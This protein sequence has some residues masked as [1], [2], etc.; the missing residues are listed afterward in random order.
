MNRDLVL[1]VLRTFASDGELQAPQALLDLIDLLARTH[2]TM[3]NDDWEVIATVGG[4][5]WRA[6]MGGVEAEAHFELL[7]RRL[8]K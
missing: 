8:R 3:D 1:A 2:S 7:M 5:L 6:E 4:L